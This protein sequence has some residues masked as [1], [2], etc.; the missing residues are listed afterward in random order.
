MGDFKT[1]SIGFEAADRFSGKFNEILSKLDR[2]T[3]MVHKIDIGV[4]AGTISRIESSTNRVTNAVKRSTTE[5]GSQKRALD[6]ASAGFRSLA[7]SMDRAAGSHGRFGGILDSLKGKFSG[8][9]T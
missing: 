3:K 5:F 1:Y 2:L 7:D 4:D 8:F 6:Q 9:W